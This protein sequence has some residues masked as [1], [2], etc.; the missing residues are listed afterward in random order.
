MNNE[1]AFEFYRDVTSIDDIRGKKESTTFVC[2][3][4]D[5]E[6]NYLPHTVYVYHLS[7]FFYLFYTKDGITLFEC[8]TSTVSCRQCENHFIKYYCSLSYR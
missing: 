1:Q 3:C 7:C 8:R 4:L 2:I 6:G 5:D